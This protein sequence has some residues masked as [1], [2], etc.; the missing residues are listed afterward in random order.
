MIPIKRQAKSQSH[1]G[2]P[3]SQGNPSTH[4][5]SDADPSCLA[6][7]CAPSR[8]RP[9]QEKDKACCDGG[10]PRCECPLDCAGAR[11]DVVS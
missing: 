6:S 7:C 5:S 4:G 11:D 10:C 2:C 9:L 8:G 3:V 1:G